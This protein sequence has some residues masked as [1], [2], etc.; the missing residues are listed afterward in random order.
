M[1][2]KRDG[3]FYVGVTS[4]LIGDDSKT[5]SPIETLGDVWINPLK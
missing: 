4:D 5:I 3:M 1:A 2:S